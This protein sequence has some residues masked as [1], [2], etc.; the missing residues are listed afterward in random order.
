MNVRACAGSSASSGSAISSLAVNT[1]GRRE[2]D[3]GIEAEGCRS[4]PRLRATRAESS[5]SRTVVDASGR[6]LKLPPAPRAVAAS[7]RPGARWSARPARP[8]AALSRLWTVKLIRWSVT[9]RWGRVVGADLLRA[10]ARADLRLA[11]GAERRLLLGQLGLVELRAQQLHRPLAVQLL[12][13]A[14]HRDRRSRTARG[15]TRTAES[16]VFTDWPRGP[17]RRAVDV[18]LQVVLVDADLDVLDLGQHRDGRGG[19]VDAAL[20]LWSP[21]PAARGGCRLRT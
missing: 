1:H 20:G 3:L 8:R 6:R 15:V 12:F 11:V 4:P 14:L 5:A 18:D 21:A 16:V 9:R 7:R 13:L 17:R 10:V 19:G 2:Q